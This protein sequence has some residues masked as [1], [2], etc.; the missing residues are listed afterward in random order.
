LKAHESDVQKAFQQWFNAW[1]DRET[2]RQIDESPVLVKRQVI[3][4]RVRD[5]AM[6][7]I[8]LRIERACGD[9]LEMVQFENEVVRELLEKEKAR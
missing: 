3:R 4:R 7:M 8:V 2:D 5:E 1:V 9:R 6:A